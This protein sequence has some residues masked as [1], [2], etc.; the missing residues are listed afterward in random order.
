VPG[1]RN[2]R[3]RPV[4]HN[5]RTEQKGVSMTAPFIV[6]YTYAINEGKLEDF[7]QFLQELFKVLDANE[8]RALAVN[9]YVNED[10]TE[11]SM[12]Q[13]HPGAA[14]LEQFWQALHKHTGRALGDFVGATTSFQVYGAPSDVALRR[15]RQLADLGVAVS[16][17][18]EHLGGFARLSSLVAVT[19]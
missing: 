1:W 11:A 6:I 17:K 13:V 4:A 19:A 16:V 9:V 12:V 3:Q 10:G 14:S 2:A 5:A 18:P 7:R 15:A 8:P